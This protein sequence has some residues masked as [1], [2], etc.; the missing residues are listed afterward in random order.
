M[1]LKRADGLYTASEV[2]GLSGST[3]RTIRYWGLVGILQPT[4]DS[5]N[6]GT[7]VHRT[8]T[9]EECVVACVVRYFGDKGLQVGQ[10]MPL[11]HNV[12]FTFF[13]PNAS[14]FLRAAIRDE[15]R[16]YMTMTDTGS[17]RLSDEAE[18]R[19]VATKLLTEMSEAVPGFI[20]VLLNAV[21][22]PLRAEWI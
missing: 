22:A 15:Q 10:L 4:A 21:F 17:I 12:R 18:I 9:R 6:S 8:F 19:D 20:G 7:G 1:G 5:T 16:I 3:Q 11:S 13:T 2:A 14:P